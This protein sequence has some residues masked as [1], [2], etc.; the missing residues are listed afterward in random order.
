[1][2]RLEDND[3]NL[4]KFFNVNESGR[5]I[6][7]MI[8]GTLTVE[9]F[10]TAFCK[11][12]EIDLDDNKGWIERFIKEMMQKDAMLVTENPE[13]HKIIFQD[14]KDRISPMHAAIEITEKCNLRCKHCY[15]EADICKSAMIE[16][17][18]FAKLVD[19]LVEN[20]VVGVEITGGEIFM[21]P[22]VYDILKLCYKKFAT[23]GVLTNGTVMTDDVLELIA[24]HKDRTIVNISID[25]ID[26]S[27]HDEFRGMKGAWQASCNTVKK[28]SEKGIKVRVASSISQENMWDIDKLAALSVSLGAATFSFNFIEEFGRGAN[29]DAGNDYIKM[30]DFSDYIGKVIREYKDIIPIVRENDN[31]GAKVRENCG[32]GT[33]SMVIGADGSV[34]P[35]QLSPKVNFMGNILEEE[36]TDMFSKPKIKRIGEVPPPDIRNGCD[37]ECEHLNRCHGCF[38]KGIEKNKHMDS[39]CKWITENHLEDVLEMFTA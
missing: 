27:S 38:I 2:V 23:V 1:M 39:P 29:I 13:E 15:L 7:E 34:R 17:E 11:K 37:S 22:Q 8:D 24:S 19:K 26:A 33:R 5:K 21:H 31:T 14:D 16:Y 30:K 35:C 18:Q 25:S 12:Y 28:L 4:Y 10:I 6:F 3:D 9:D 32:S 36:F 20:N